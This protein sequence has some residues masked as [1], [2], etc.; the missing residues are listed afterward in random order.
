MVSITTMVS[1]S[2]WTPLILIQQWTDMLRFAFLQWGSYKSLSCCDFNSIIYEEKPVNKYFVWTHEKVRM[3]MSSNKVLQYSKLQII[4]EAVVNYSWI[5]MLPWYD[6]VNELYL[7]FNIFFDMG[8]WY[9]KKHNRNLVSSS[10]VNLIVK[11]LIL[12]ALDWIQ[13]AH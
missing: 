12:D 2:P 11:N 1:A 7:H 4:I 13:N 3:E 5:L 6:N 9:H 10:H 8:G